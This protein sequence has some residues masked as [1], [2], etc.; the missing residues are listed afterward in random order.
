[1]Y[2]RITRRTSLPGRCDRACLS[3][4]ASQRDAHSSKRNTRVPTKGAKETDQKCRRGWNRRQG[5]VATAGAQH[6]SAP[7]PTNSPTRKQQDDKEASIVPR[8]ASRPLPLPVPVWPFTV[9][10]SRGRNEIDAPRARV[11]VSPSVMIAA[12]TQHH[13]RLWAR[14]SFISTGCWGKFY[15]YTAT[16]QETTARSY[17]PA[18]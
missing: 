5:N 4:V 11:G 6:S 15:K 8:V 18:S 17:S 7:N 1:M 13:H 12:V 10:R 14:E 3:S 2:C 9:K 16:G